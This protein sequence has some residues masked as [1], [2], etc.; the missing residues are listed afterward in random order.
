MGFVPRGVTA[1]VT[2]C[3]VA[4]GVH[5]R[6]WTCLSSLVQHQSAASFDVV[7]VVNPDGQDD[8]DASRVP[9][10]IEVVQP[11]MN[12]GWAGGLHAARAVTNARYLAWIQDD[13]EV[14]PGWL[15]ALLSAAMDHEDG[16]AFGVIAVDGNG[17]PSGHSGGR[18]WPPRD[19]GAWNDTD[20]T[21]GG[22]MPLS[23]EDRDWV[24]SKGLLVR[25]KAWDDVG[26]P[27]PRQYPLNHVDKE[28]STHLRAHGWRVYVVP[29]SNLLHMQGKS[30]PSLFRHF[31]AQWQ[32][33]PFAD[34][35]GDVVERM[36][37][38]GGGPVP[39]D[40]QGHPDLATVEAECGREATR[41]VVPLSRFAAQWVVDKE[42]LAR[43]DIEVLADERDKAVQD[44]EMTLGSTSWRVTAPLRAVAGLARRVLRR[45]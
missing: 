28:F 37:S 20:P 33:D 44:L 24:T 23:V 45:R 9:P 35:W 34:Q 36:A 26:G 12:L 16:A 32:A 39:H 22:V 13:C 4:Y 29:E 21:V 31:L 1:E 30:S 15:D 43:R 10:G 25:T 18:A 5:E 2:L 3:V 8:P 38:A 42:Y 19:V 17:V 40:C 41:M 6:L 11:N 27:S 14:L 7:C